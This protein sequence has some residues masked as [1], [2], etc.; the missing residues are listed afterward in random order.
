VPT[1][2]PLAIQTHHLLARAKFQWRQVRGLDG[3]ARAAY[4]RQRFELFTDHWSTRAGHWLFERLTGFGLPRPAWL[5]TCTYSNEWAEL[6]YRPRPYFGPVLMVRAAEPVARVYPLPL[7]GW[8]E[9]LRGEVTVIERPLDQRLLWQNEE[10][11]RL[12]AQVI[13]ERIGA[14]ERGGRRAVQ[15]AND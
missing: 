11:M 12:I 7:M 1:A 15:A 2:S 4:A 8:A 10:S 6:R 5:Q 9:L 14:Y 3:P 13:G